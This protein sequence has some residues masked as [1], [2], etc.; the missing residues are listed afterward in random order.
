MV[1]DFFFFFFFWGSMEKDMK[2]KETS[3]LTLFFYLQL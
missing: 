2:V 1:K 3:D